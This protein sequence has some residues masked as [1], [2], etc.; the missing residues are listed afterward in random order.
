MSHIHRK[1]K[2]Y[3]EKI[4]NILCDGEIPERLA[5]A[6]IRFEKDIDEFRLNETD[7]IDFKYQIGGL[8][9]PQM[10]LWPEYVRNKILFQMEWQLMY[11]LRRIQMHPE[12]LDRDLAVEYEGL[13]IQEVSFIF[14]LRAYKFIEMSNRL[15][16]HIYSHHGL[17]TVGA[18]E[19][20]T[21]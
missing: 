2:K 3:V 6:V 15:M 14:Q 7:L 20:R 17:T 13:Q 19:S 10:N 16:I 21:F 4:T 5:G 11:K 9:K 1:F 12:L 18:T 8:S